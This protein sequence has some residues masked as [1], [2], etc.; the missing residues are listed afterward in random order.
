MAQSNSGFDGLKINGDVR[1]TALSGS[2]SALDGDAGIV[3]VNPAGMAASTASSVMFQY[4]KTG[5]GSEFST[6]SAVIKDGVN[7]FSAHAA[8]LVIPGI[9]IRGVVPAD[10]ADGIVDAFNLVVGF[11]YARSWKRLQAGI[12][13]KY[14]F[15]KYYL[16]NASGFAVDFGVRITAIAPGTDWGFSIRNLGRMAP[17]EKKSTPLPLTLRSGFAYK[18]FEDMLGDQLILLPELILRRGESLS[19]AMG[20][21]Y[22]PFSHLRLMAGMRTRGESVA[23]SGGV[24]LLYKDLVV[25]YAYDTTGYGVQ[26]THSFGVAYYF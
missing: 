8:Y 3:F 11:G 22:T 18:L 23:G 4:R 16:N 6:M 19:Y 24:S 2:G 7:A 1:T 5:F 13:L 17:L 20:L 14:L 12:N 21:L 9:E 10:E 25:R 15:E 26:G